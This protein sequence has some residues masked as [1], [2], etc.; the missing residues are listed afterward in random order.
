MNPDKKIIV[1]ELLERVNG[2]PFL[3]VV[4]YNGMTVPEFS[5]LRNRLSEVGAECHVGK[6]R[7]MRIAIEEAGLPSLGDDLRGQTAFVTGA[8]DVCG[9]AK[10]IKNFA[11]EF[12]KPEVKVGLLDGAVVDTAQI[13]ALADLPSREVLLAKLLSV[14]NAPA[15]K[16][17]RTINEPGS[18]LA[19]V[20]K[21]K[22]PDGE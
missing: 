10:V 2:S 11:K 5:E 22:Y 19:R 6:N 4:D 18:A 1:D 3:L 17:V 8:D 16:L 12:K 14:I 15:S 7:F 13:D 9:A 20:I 21:A